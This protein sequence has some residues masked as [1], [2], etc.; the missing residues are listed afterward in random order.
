MKKWFIRI[1]ILCFLLLISF[2]YLF[3]PDNLTISESVLVKTNPKGAY[4]CLIDK[5]QWR[6][7]F[8]ITIT[9][10]TFDYNG[11][12]YI[13]EEKTMDGLI[14]HIKDEDSSTKGVIKILP[15]SNDSSVIVWESSIYTDLN[16]VKKIN[17]LLSEKKGKLVV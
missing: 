2:I 15:L 1:G 13:V 11:E 4:R 7:L 6:Q 12:Q 3:V 16:P 9:K 10:N 5:N 17:L 14:V 8:G